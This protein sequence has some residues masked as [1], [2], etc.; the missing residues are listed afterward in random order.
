MGCCNAI[1]CCASNATGCCIVV[2]NAGC[3][4][5]GSATDCCNTIVC[6]SVRNCCIAGNGGG[7]ESCCWTMLIKSEAGTCVRG[8]VDCLGE[9]M[10]HHCCSFSGHEVA[11]RQVVTECFGWQLGKS[12]NTG[13]QNVQKELMTFKFSA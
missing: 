8:S 5:D 4:I 3:C 1:D 6:A 9:L 12:S 7:E 2:S 11:Q 10:S 13:L